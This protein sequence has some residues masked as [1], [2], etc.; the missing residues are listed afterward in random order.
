V[1]QQ[2]EE[3]Q[4]EWQR[5][6]HQQQHRVSLQHQRTQLQLWERCHSNRVVYADWPAVRHCVGGWAVLVGQQP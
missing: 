5:K 1:L 2:Q 3:Q 6:Q 4:Q